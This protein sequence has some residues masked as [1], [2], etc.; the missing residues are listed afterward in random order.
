MVV[1][2]SSDAR[3][4]TLLATVRLWLPRFKSYLLDSDARISQCWSSICSGNLICDTC[5]SHPS[6]E[7]IQTLN[8]SLDFSLT[9]WINTVSGTLLKKLVAPSLNYSLQRIDLRT[10]VMMSVRQL[11]E[12]SVEWD[13]YF[14][15]LRAQ[16]YSPANI[17]LSKTRTSPSVCYS[18]CWHASTHNRT[19]TVNGSEKQ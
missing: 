17:S 5:L 18:H 6:F 9:S 15:L 12:I 4:P 13:S 19:W 7:V 8:P 1:S 16:Q 3:R 11:L 2:H 14:L 10:V